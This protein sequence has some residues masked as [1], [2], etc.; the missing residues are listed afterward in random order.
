MKALDSVLFLFCESS[1]MTPVV[2]AEPNF[3]YITHARNYLSYRPHVSMGYKL[4]NYA[5]SW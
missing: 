4:I 2:S 3:G 1:R 5:G